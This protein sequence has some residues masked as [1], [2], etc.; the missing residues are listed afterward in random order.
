[1]SKDRIY[2]K[3][4]LDMKPYKLQVKTDVYYLDI[5]NRIKQLLH[6]K[7]IDVQLSD[8]IFPEE[9]DLLACFLTSYFED[10]ISGTNLWNTFIQGHKE[11]YNTPLPFFEIDKDDYFEGEINRDDIDILVWYFINTIQQE[12]LISPHILFIEN[13]EAWGDAVFDLFASEWERAPENENLR[14]FYSISENTSDFYDAREFIDRILFSSYL[15]FT[16]TQIRLREIEY[17]IITDNQRSPLLVQ[18]LRASHDDLLFTA[19]THL[20]AFSGKE[21]AA[22]WVGKDSPLY[23]EYLNISRKITGFFF[24]KGQDD[25]TIFIEH[26]ASGKKFNL[27]KKSIDRPEDFKDID[28]IIY[29]G[30]VEWCGEWWFSGIY[31]FA[32]FNA[33]LVLDEKN[34]AASRAAVNFL[35]FKKNNVEARLSED[36]EQFKKF[37]GGQQI[38]FMEA[39]KVN[40]FLNS[41]IQSMND[42]LNL[43]EEELKKGEERRRK[44]GFFNDDKDSKLNLPDGA[45]TAFVFFNPKQG[46]EIGFDLNSAFPLPHNPFFNKEESTEHVKT[47]LF[48]D[49]FSVEIVQYMI[50]HCKSK[51]PFFDETSVGSFYLD[52][53]DFILRFIKTDN[54]TT[55]P[56]I[57]FI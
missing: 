8:I 21:W 40:D 11:L 7:E 53:L 48:D 51:L 55:Q 56:E 16:D 17:R 35:D 9:I 49:S 23:N 3:K 18:Y 6:S 19:H 37:T 12:K 29:I 43:S 14:K 13:F 30:I 34:S 41:H 45:K 26:I 52:D 15:F 31:S 32:P 28:D 33:D 25:K 2:I 50:E 24:Y 10:L 5:C 20:L 39:D 54:Y 27:T 47:L 1:M 38:V 46:I 36:L 22:R 4:W 44:D 57:S 42:A